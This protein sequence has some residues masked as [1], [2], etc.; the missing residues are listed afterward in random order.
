MAADFSSL[1]A[2]ATDSLMAEWLTPAVGD[3]VDGV[4]VCAT[5]RLAASL[6]QRHARQRAAAGDGV[7]PAPTCLPW[8]GWL[9]QQYEALALLRAGRGAT[10]PALL[11]EAETRALWLQIIAQ[12][13][14][15]QPLL[16]PELT[17]R[18][19]LDAWQQAHAGGLALPLRE[20]GDPDARAFNHWSGQYRRRLEALSAWDLAQLPLRLAEA[21]ADG[22]LRPPASLTLAGFDSLTVAQT[23]LVEA[24]AAAGGHIRR[25]STPTFDSHRLR[26]SAGTPQQELAQAAAQVRAWSEARPE[27]RIGVVIPALAE[28]RAAVL[29]AFDAALCPDRREDAPRPY[30]LSLGQPLAEQALVADA[31]AWLDWACGRALPAEAVAARLFSGYWR[32]SDALAEAARLDADWRRRRYARLTL[33]AAAALARRAA[34][35]H[36]DGASGSIGTMLAALRLPGG[37]HPP[38]GWARH[39]AAAL[40]ALGWP[41]AQD[42]GSEDWQAWQAWRQQLLGLGRLDRLLGPVPAREALRLLRAQLGDTLFQAESVDTPIQVLGALETA[43]LDFDHLL[44]LGLDELSWPPPPSPNPFLPLALQRAARLPGADARLQLEQAR[45]ITTRLMRAAPEVRVS[46]ARQFDDELRLPS[47]LIAD[48]PEGPAPASIEAPPLIAQL[49]PLADSHGPGVAAGEAVAGGT[50]RLAD[51]AACPFRGY[52]RHALGAAA[53]EAVQ[54]PLD[55]RERGLL[56]HDAL[57]RLWREL[58]SQRVLLAMDDDARHG[59]VARHVGLALDA[60]AARS[61]H[62]LTPVARRLEAARLQRLIGELLAADA[63]RPPFTVAIIEGQ[64][65]QPEAGPAPEAQH[66]AGLVWRTRP[67][68]IDDCDGQHLVID[69]KTGRAAPFGDERL[70]APQLPFYALHDPDS[71]GVAYA[72]LR[73]GEVGYQG[74]RD[75][76]ADALPDTLRPVSRALPAERREAGWPGL[77][78]HWRQQLETLAGEIAAGLAS[79]TPW[80]PQSCAACDLQALCRIHEQATRTT[81]DV[82]GART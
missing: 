44:L 8:S 32:G 81:A 82:D 41:R 2:I 15:D 58:G 79:V 78:R 45:Q 36:D 29:R 6:V 46:H 10:P 16:Q 14:R 39:F 22:E 53:P 51:Q 33:P 49:E 72:L 64:P 71:A 50:Q 13:R 37:A 80:S 11:S 66:F 70:L 76:E 35:R 55:H 75:D 60:Y 67:D 63:A 18:L 31:L 12:A 34:A 40:D 30:N 68:R 59:L 20:T 77:R 74:L 38:G 57:A 7:W 26:S 4:T 47:P 73:P 54:P 24:I 69:Y 42:L 52:A 1:N 65:A 23:R 3:A 5:R 28:R 61:P 43:G 21:Y 9:L 62:R 25:L 19:A 48:L 17:A 27:A 56:A